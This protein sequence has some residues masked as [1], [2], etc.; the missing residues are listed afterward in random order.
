MSFLKRGPKK[1][2]VTV[3][4][5]SRTG[6][7]KFYKTKAKLNPEF[8]YRSENQDYHVKK[9]G[10]YKLK[11]SGLKPVKNLIRNEAP[12]LIAFRYGDSTHLMP[13]NPQISPEE[14]AIYATSRALRDGINEKFKEGMDSKALIGGA[15][16]LVIL[17]LLAVY[18]GWMPA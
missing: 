13:G 12:Y 4:I 10:L 9:S 3:L 11:E 6:R 17:Y 14:L 8:V 18:M 1:Y 15:G 16:I 5:I 7:F 2:R